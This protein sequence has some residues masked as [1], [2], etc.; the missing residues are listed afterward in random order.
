MLKTYKP[1]LIVCGVHLTA[2]Y[3]S[4]YFSELNNMDCVLNEGGHRTCFPRRR[5]LFYSSDKLQNLS[6]LLQPFNTFI[7]ILHCASI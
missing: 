3:V 7:Y 1:S 5:L 4:Q 6:Y 2:N